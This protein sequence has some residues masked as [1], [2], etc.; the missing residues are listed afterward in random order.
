MIDPSDINHLGIFGGC[1]AFEIPLVVGRPNIGNR[2]VFINSVNDILDRKW[3]TND[4]IY[5]QELERQIAKKI[6]VKH[7]IATCNATIALEIV[8]KALNMS[9]EVI[10]PSFTFIATAHALKWQNIDP[11]F[12]DIDELTHNIDP[13]RI[14]ELITPQTTGIVGVHLWG[15]PCDINKLEM[16]AEE[17]KL[18]LI[19]DAAHAFGCS[20]NKQ[21][22]GNFGNAEVFSFHATKFFNTFEGGAIVTNDNDLASILRQMRNFGFAG[23]DNVVRIGTNGKMNEISAAMGL[24]ELEN[25]NDFLD[26][27]YRNYKQYEK[28]VANIPGLT[29]LKY[30]EQEKCNY[31]YIVVEVNETITHI[32]RDLI[33]KIL[34][35]ENIFARRYFY[36]G[37]HNMEPYKSDLSGIKAFLPSTEKIIQ[38]VL[39]LPNGTSLDPKDVAKV[40][41]IL[42]FIV[43]NGKELSLKCSE[44]DS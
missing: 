7:C 2:S 31:Q 18:K 30:N 6:G 36:P 25:F 16:I 4:G 17:N 34:T 22:V 12:C 42:R 32:S 11:V 5:V 19:F 10:I 24:A 44:S 23:Y 40:C 3:L 20:Y 14:V 38:R 9:G 26:I 41:S 37:C 35:A 43:K 8:V 13:D 15:R 29:I 33:L 27:N 28:K 1:P 21:M 39:V